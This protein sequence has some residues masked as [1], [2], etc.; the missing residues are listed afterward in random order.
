MHWF[1]L[2]DTPAVK[3]VH[4]GSLA[5]SGRAY[6]YFGRDRR[7]IEVG[8]SFL[9]DLRWFELSAD[10]SEEDGLGFSL[11]LPW[12]AHLYA[13]ISLPSRWLRWWMIHDRHFAVKLGYIGDIAWVLIAYADWA[14]SCGMTDYYRRQDPPQ[15][16]PL[17]LWP[18]WEIK[19]KWPPLVRWIF[20]RENVQSRVLD[21][22]PVT[23]NFDGR[24][25]TGH[26][27]LEEYSRTRQ[28]WPWRY[29]R[30]LSSWID[31]AK[32]PMFAGKGENSWD[33]DD[34]A[35]FGMGSSERTCAGA[36]GEYIKAVLKNRERYGQ[37]RKEA[38]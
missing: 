32:P 22:K 11:I 9:R 20:G 14:E 28:R 19:V 34:D 3:G 7:R 29:G 24:E 23:F 18:G 16:T 1:V 38:S 6:F 33:C 30:S 25:Y 2:N 27:K 12:L 5:R 21:E 36:V 15:Y 31:V 17:Q 37:P 26:W 10:I 8:W 35:I 13:S 4:L